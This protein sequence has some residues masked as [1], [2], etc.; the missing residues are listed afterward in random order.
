MTVLREGLEAVVFV[1][2]VSF[3][4]SAKAIPIAAIVG[5]LCGL[6]VG[7]AIYMSSRRVSKSFSYVHVV[8]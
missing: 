4:E 2:G 1:A 5:L 6:I 3:G 8:K 7:A